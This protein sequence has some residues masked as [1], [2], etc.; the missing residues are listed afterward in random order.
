MALLRERTNVRALAAVFA[1]ALVLRVWGIS[2]GLPYDFTADEPHQIIQ[3]LK[4]GAGDAGPLVRM[5]HTVGKSGLD[6]ILFVEYG[7]LFVTL[8]VFG[9]VEGP[10][11]FALLYLQDPTLFYLVGR[12]TIAVL[13]ALTCVFVYLVGRRLYDG[14]TGLAAAILGAVAYYHA[15]ESH[16]INVHIAMTCAL[17]G[18]VLAFVRFEHNGRRRWLVA[19]GV[20]CGAAI[21]LAYTAG[22]GLLFMLAA[23]AFA[24]GSASRPGTVLRDGATFA[25]AAVAAI[26]VMSPD[27]LLGAN[28]L[29]QNFSQL[30]GGAT[31]AAPPPDSP[32]AAIDSVTILRQ[33][34]WTGFAVLLLKPYNLLLTAAAV[35][36]ALA[37]LWR[38]ERWTM[39]LAAAVAA[40]LLI[41]SAS[42]RGQ[43]E[44]YL[45]A[46]TPALWLLGAR[47][48]QALARGRAAAFAALVAVVA[49]VPLYSIVRDDM[50]L[51]R[52]DT[53]VLAKQW[54]EAH[55]PAGSKI[56]MDG[57]R[58]RFVQSPPLNPDRTTVER[59]LQDLESSELAVSGDM[60]ALYR[61]AAEQV[62]GPTY[63]LH[64]TMY[65][66]EVED[67]D[68][69]VAHGFDYVVVSSFNEKRYEAEAS[70][71]RYPRSAAFYQQI[72]SDPRF[73]QVYAIEPLEWQRNGP[74]ITVYEVVRPP[75]T[76]EA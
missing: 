24:P 64:S 61:E 53:R 46:I 56:L 42:N 33:Q 35:A 25:G 39:I 73:R 59:R 26:A 41:V 2:F 16:I 31:G 47:G 5:W 72:R 48:L 15:A 7:L 50:M 43:S 63:E 1:L 74:T 54:I 20:L 62:A 58:F 75:E 52:D 51:S 69:Y 45:L 40:F 6:Y 13:G 44:A 29:I 37:G 22:I 60:L 9:R 36:G 55:V 66:L 3:A 8:W 28:L 32:R 65:G 23:L 67:L 14:R 57:M 49:A 17:W 21:A 34:D 76:P 11:D 27:L 12:V 71:S 19:A 70:R 38:R 68:Y 4:I 18:G 30:L 10:R